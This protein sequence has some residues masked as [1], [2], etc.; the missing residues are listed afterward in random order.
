MPKTDLEVWDEVREWL[1][2]LNSGGRC[3][4]NQECGSCSGINL[5]VI[6]FE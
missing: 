6:F 3:I 2:L 5:C 4:N 1:S